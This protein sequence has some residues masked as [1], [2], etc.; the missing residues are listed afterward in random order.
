MDK[1]PLVSIGVPCFNSEKYLIET[2]TSIY[3]QSY[4]D[5]ELIVYND[6]SKDGT[7]NLVLNEIKKGRK[8][9]YYTNSNNGIAY[10][11]NEIA[12]VA[13]GEFIIILDSDD[14]LYPIAVENLVNTIVKTN[15][16]FVFSNY[17][18][19]SGQIPKTMLNA[20]NNS[21]HIN[22]IYRAINS[23]LK[24]KFISFLHFHFSILP[25]GSIYKKQIL[26]EI[27]HDTNLK[28]GVDYEFQLR[29]LLNGYDNFNFINKILVKRRIHK[30]NLT[31]NKAGVRESVIYTY[32]KL[33][34]PNKLGINSD[35][36]LYQLYKRYAKSDFKSKDFNSCLKNYLESRR[37]RNFYSVHLSMHIRAILSYFKIK[38][39]N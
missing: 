31:S 4:D 2:L 9:C 24:D 22:N 19:F 36:M 28:Q 8:I 23:G 1:N 10:A 29:V 27:Q 37:H 35:E 16:S 12:K 18:N 13:H 21:Q 17:F 34:I 39:S 14:I 30:T 20:F 33:L 3:K 15:S 25:S 32:K 6:G 38:F 11:R 26:D 5:I 7:E